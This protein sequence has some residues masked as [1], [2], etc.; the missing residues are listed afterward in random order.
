MGTPDFAVKSLER[1]YSD[2]HDIAAVFTKPDKPCKRGMKVSL[3]P[4]K[5]IALNRGTPVFQPVSLNGGAVLDKLNELRCELIVVVAYGKILP[6]EILEAPRSG[7]VNIHA[8]LLP[9]YRGAAPIQWAVLNGERETGVT[10]MYMAP[11]LDAGDILFSRKTPI[12]ENETAGELY[13]RLKYISAELL[14]DT[15]SAILSGEAAGIPQNHDEATFAP[16]LSKDMAPIDWAETAFVIRN[17]VRGLNPWP[18]ATASLNNVTFKVFDVDTN[19]G[20]FTGAAGVIV[21]SGENGIEV[22][23][24]DGTVIIKELQAPGGK[25]MS[26]AQ[27]L[28]GHHI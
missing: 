3:S 24:A 6:R 8:S 25:R 4:V 17:K 23:C 1:L 21:S 20:G 14:G 15:I 18:V 2:G 12:G 9:K 13:D 7:C 26:A 27:Y 22:S 11:D 28:R 5:E 16:P 10:S 19:R